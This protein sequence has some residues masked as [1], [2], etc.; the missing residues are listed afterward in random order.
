MNKIVVHLPDSLKHLTGNSRMVESAA[1]S[2]YRCIEELE[3]RFAGLM[4]VLCN[5]DGNLSDLF[6]IFVNGNNILNLQGMKTAL[7]DGDE[8][9]IIPYAAGG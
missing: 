2:I 6:L 1:G 8:L 4:N 9:T 3:A 5:E 7:K